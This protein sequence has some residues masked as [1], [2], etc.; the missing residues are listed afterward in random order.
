MRA[1]LLYEPWETSITLWGRNLTDEEY[2]TTIADSPAQTGRYNAYYSEPLTWG[3]TL[4]K[5][6]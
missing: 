5:D 6:F 1:G 2:T 3:L 4:R